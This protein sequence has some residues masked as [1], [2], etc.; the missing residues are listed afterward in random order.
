MAAPCWA[1]TGIAWLGPGN[2]K[3]GKNYDPEKDCTHVFMA[4]AC[5]TAHKYHLPDDDAQR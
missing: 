4:V 1:C 5:I 3:D 2:N